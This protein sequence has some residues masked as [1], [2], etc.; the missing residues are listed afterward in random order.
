[1]MIRY[2]GDHSSHRRHSVTGM[3]GPAETRIPRFAFTLVEVLISVMILAILATVM[4]STDSGSQQQMLEA[5]ARILAS[6][7]RL[8]RSHAIEFN[9]TYT[10]QFSLQNNSYEIRHSGS[11][12]APVLT[13]PVAGP[14]ADPSRY[15]V[16]LQSPSLGRNAAAGPRLARVGLRPTGEQVASVTFQPTGGTGPTQ[17]KDTVIILTAGRGTTS[18]YQRLVISWVTGQVWADPIDVW[19]AK[20]I[21]TLFD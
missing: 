11:G 8:A 20:T 14:N 6:D 7:L 5:T 10:V 17:A 15:V 4:V 12:S 21:T 9:T 2:P 19:N 1:M 3:I 13:N 18:Y 16:S